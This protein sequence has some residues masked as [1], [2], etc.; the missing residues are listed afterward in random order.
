M[1]NKLLLL[2][3]VFCLS[4]A[5][6]VGQEKQEVLKLK[7]VIM[8]NDYHENIAWVKSKP[9]ALESKDFTVSTYDVIYIQLY[10]GIYVEDGEQK[11]TP[12]HIVNSYNNV[13]WIFFDEI[14]YL[15]GSKKEVRAGEG[16]RYK[17][18]DNDT[19]REVNGRVTEVSDVLLNSSTTSFVKYILEQ[20]VTRLEIRYLNNK[21]N[22][23]FD[24]TVHGGTKLM[25]KHFSALIT[26][27]NQVN[28]K[29]SLNKTF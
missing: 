21:D 20:P 3:T 7:G 15:L 18:H 26:A 1:K 6:T 11:T 25:K 8:K 17:L 24:L 22:K 29:Y 23:S 2:L 10:F 9:I 19:K 27:Y 28:K 14:S 12:I 5:I 4:S 16:K 13:N